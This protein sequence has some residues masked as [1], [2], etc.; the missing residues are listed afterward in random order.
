MKFL[1]LPLLATVTLPVEGIE[2]LLLRMGAGAAASGAVWA[3]WGR[4]IQRGILKHRVQQNERLE[5]IE[6]QVKANGS[7]LLLPEHQRDLPLADLLVLHIVETAPLIKL[8]V[9]QQRDADLRD[10]NEPT[11]Q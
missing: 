5:R 2:G 10:R 7:R 9:S 11:P 3:W 8:F 4:P 1:I 6:T